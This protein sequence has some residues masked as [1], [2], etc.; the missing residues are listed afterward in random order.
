M[1]VHD[2]HIYCPTIVSLEDDSE[3]E[4]IVVE[5]EGSSAKEVIC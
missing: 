2:A 1:A 5:L 4:V 3:L